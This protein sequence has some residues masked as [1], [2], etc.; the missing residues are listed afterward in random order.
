MSQPGQRMWEVDYILKASFDESKIKRDGEGQ[1]SSN[2]GSKSENSGGKYKPFGDTRG[3][4]EIDF[5]KV[6]VL[7]P[8]K[9]KAKKPTTKREKLNFLHRKYFGKDIPKD[10]T[11]TY[12]AELIRQS[13]RAG[14][15][16]PRS[17][18]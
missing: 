9:P 4:H 17:S 16:K 7:E 13:A 1:F 10:M 2:G 8:D 6:P 12:A 18:R 5:D 14:D 11:D 15:E 3:L